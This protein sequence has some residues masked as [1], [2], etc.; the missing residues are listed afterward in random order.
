MRPCHRPLSL[1]LL[2]PSTSRDPLPYVGRH[3]QFGCVVRRST[4]SSAAATE[5][6]FAVSGGGGGGSRGGV[7]GG[8]CGR[9]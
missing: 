7:V 5:L 6:T 1:L 4:T 8:G 2:R 3:S 9:G